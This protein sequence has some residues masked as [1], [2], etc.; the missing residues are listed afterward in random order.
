MVIL[1]SPIFLSVI[2]CWAPERDAYEPIASKRHIAILRERRRD[3]FS[4]TS[5]GLVVGMQEVAMWMKKS[6][7]VW[8]G[9][10]GGWTPSIRVSE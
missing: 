2:V 1:R 7:H 10:W 6:R 9:A 3:A 8:V 4:R 5:G